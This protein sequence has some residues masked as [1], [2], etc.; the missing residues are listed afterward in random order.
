MVEY[1]LSE[2]NRHS[3]LIGSDINLVQAGG[4]NTS[5]KNDQGIWVKVSGKRLRDALSEDIF[6]FINAPKLSAREIANQ[7]DF[8]PF[9]SSNF[10][11][12]IET[13]FHLLIESTFVTHIHSLGAISLGICHNST[14]LDL[15]LGDYITFPYRQPGVSLANAI[16]DLIPLSSSTLLLDNHGIIFSG[17]SLEIIEEKISEFEK[18]VLHYF[19]KLRDNPKYPGWVEILVSGV[20][21]PDEAVYLG[22]KPFVKSNSASIDSVSIN[23]LGK[24]LFHK[25]HTNDQKNLA[26]F[27][28]RVAKVIEKK[29]FVN[30]LPPSEVNRLLEWD[31]EKTRLGMA[32]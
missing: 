5:W 16:L 18:S 4:G 29:T 23:H 21:T 19:S 17:D 3:H 11:P 13:N 32:K 24:L 25:N 15:K 22:K 27:Y 20:L 1:G 8:T 7:I 28:M 12:S 10:T 31:R 6:C 30:Y 26:K 9:T 2:L 14:R